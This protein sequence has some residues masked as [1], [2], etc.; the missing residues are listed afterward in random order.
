[1][2]D[3][4]SRLVA[5]ESALLQR[6]KS[7][8]AFYALAGFLCGRICMATTVIL[9]ITPAGIVVGAD[10]KVNAVCTD[11][12]DD[13]IDDNA[14]IPKVFLVQGRFA[15]ASMGLLRADVLDTHDKPLFLYDFP[16]WVQYIQRQLPPKGQLSDLAKM[17]RDKYKPA[18]FGLERALGDGIIAEH[19]ADATP[20]YIVI[21]YQ[22]GAAYAY[23][24]Q[25]SIDWDHRSVRTPVMTRVFPGTID[26][27]DSGL[28]I[29]GRKSAL[30]GFCDP[31]SSAHKQISE[32]FH[33]LSRFCA[34][35]HL[36]LSEAKSLILALLTLQAEHDPERVSPPFRLLTIK[37]PYSRSGWLKND[38]LPAQY[39]QRP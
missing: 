31:V 11:R 2:D 9:V 16:Q 34:G 37:R 1:V 30:G 36:S 26:R 8:M 17:V 3:S 38:N 25:A 18:L 7:K 13:C 33:N 27:V 10:G 32:R 14:R 4:L 19:S 12:N 28:R 5:S 22:S 6:I 23:S 39:S 15:I 21:G 20:S 35:H 24:I 29:M